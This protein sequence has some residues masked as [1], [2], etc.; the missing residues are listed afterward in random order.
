MYF[1]C[2]RVFFVVV[3]HRLAKKCTKIFNACRA[4]VPL[5]K[6]LFC[7]VFAAVEVYTECPCC[8]GLTVKMLTCQRIRELKQRRPRL[9][10]NEFVLYIREICN[11]LVL[12]GMPIALKT[13]PA[14]NSKWKNE[15]LAAVFRVPQTTQNLVISRS[16]LQITAKKCTKIS[17]ARAQPLFCPLSLLFVDLLVVVVIVVCLSPLLNIN[18][19]FASIL[20]I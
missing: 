2:T 3:L 12:L 15:N 5:I 4:I 20:V 13:C 16:Y 19:L 18:V 14:L 10:K 6:P 1:R 11:C 17:N 9:A 7:D 8:G